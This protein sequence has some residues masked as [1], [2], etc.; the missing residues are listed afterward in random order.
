MYG[1]YEM[2]IIELTK[3]INEINKDISYARML[4]DKYYSEYGQLRTFGGSIAHMMQVKNMWFFYEQKEGELLSKRFSMESKLEKVKK[5]WRNS[6]PKQ[7][8]FV[9]M[10]D[11][12]ILLTIHKNGIITGHK[13]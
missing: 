4:A 6:R 11:I 13:L 1:K 5:A 9:P 2:E 10:D 12:D 8:A 7:D 3:G